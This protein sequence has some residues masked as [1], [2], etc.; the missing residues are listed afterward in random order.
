MVGMPVRENYRIDL[1]RFD[2]LP[3]K[4]FEELPTRR[5]KTRWPHASVDEHTV[6]TSMDEE[7]DVAHFDLFILAIPGEGGRRRSRGTFEK[8]ISGG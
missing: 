3:A 4:M 6:R 7:T 1:V 2:A 5:S 8:K